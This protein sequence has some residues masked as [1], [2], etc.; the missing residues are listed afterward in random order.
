MHTH[1][2][3]HQPVQHRHHHPVMDS[4]DQ[5]AEE[6]DIDGIEEEDDDDDDE[7]TSSTLLPTIETYRT[8][9]NELGD[10][11]DNKL[12]VAQLGSSLKSRALTITNIFSI[13]LVL[14]VVA[15]LIYRSLRP[16]DEPGISIRSLSFSSSSASPSNWVIDG[17]EMEA[18]K[19]GNYL[20]NFKPTVLDIMYVASTTAN[21]VDN[22][23]SSS[24][25]G[26]HEE[27][28]IEEIIQVFG[29]MHVDAW[30]LSPEQSSIILSTNL[31]QAAA[32]GGGAAAAD[33]ASVFM[34]R[35]IPKAAETLAHH[36]NT[37]STFLAIRGTFLGQAKVYASLTCMI[38]LDCRILTN[39]TTAATMGTRSSI[40]PSCVSTYSRA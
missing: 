37:T 1:I 40:T 8:I 4:R 28:A 26:G 6:V 14:T 11:D 13:S 30:S 20:V 35:G 19:Q 7:N 17:V 23:G 5:H 15:A 27:V 33:E 21:G 34:G 16:V 31:Q 10:R 3:I 38:T 24:E 9:T 18:Y 22:S 39:E 2:A 25:E 32:G 12:T 29:A 36:D